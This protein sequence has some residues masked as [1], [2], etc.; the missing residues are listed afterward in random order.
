M[1]RSYKHS[2]FIQDPC[3]KR[4]GKRLANKKVR[5]ILDVPSGR[6]YQKIFNSWNIA[7]YILQAR[8]VLESFIHRP[9]R[10]FK[11]VRL[12]GPRSPF[13]W[14]DEDDKNRLWIDWRK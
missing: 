11:K 14:M 5:R 12:D 4:F 6:A 2:G 13:D 10:K 9:G 8:G 3:S 7:D 1:S